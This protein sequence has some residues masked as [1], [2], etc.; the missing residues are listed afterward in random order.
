MRLSITK[1]IG[2]GAGDLYQGPVNP[3]DVITQQQGGAS[4]GD[5]VKADHLHPV[6][7]FEYCIARMRTMECGSLRTV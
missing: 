2:P 6:T 3:G 7:T 4:L 1:R 5:I